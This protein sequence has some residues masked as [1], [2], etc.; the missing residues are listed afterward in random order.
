MTMNGKYNPVVGSST[1]QPNMH[2]HNI[3]AFEMKEEDAFTKGEMGRSLGR[4]REKERFG[5]GLG[6]PESGWNGFAIYSHFVSSPIAYNLV[7]SVI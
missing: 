1:I 2:G 5:S 7:Q 6:N 4:K 3:L